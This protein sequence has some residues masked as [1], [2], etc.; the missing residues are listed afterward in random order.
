MNN[1]Y[2]YIY[3]MFG[4]ILSRLKIKISTGKFSVGLLP[5]K[6]KDLA[7]LCTCRGTDTT[8][9]ERMHLEHLQFAN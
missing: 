6:D 2:L 9:S 7:G 5:N 4:S 1:Y 3:H 8:V